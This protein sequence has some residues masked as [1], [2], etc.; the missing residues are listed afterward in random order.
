MRLENILEKIEFYHINIYKN[1]KILVFMADINLYT[2]GN[3]VVFNGILGSS[4]YHPFVGQTTNSPEL[5]KNICEFVQEEE[6]ILRSIIPYEFLP[7]TISKIS[8]SELEKIA[9]NLRKEGIK[10]K[11]VLNQINQPNNC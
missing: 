7:K 2:Q 11:L 3:V 4:K 5:I 9:K 1:K 8:K 10:I 6:L